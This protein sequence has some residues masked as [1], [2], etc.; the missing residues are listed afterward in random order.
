MLAVFQQNFR[1]FQLYG[2]VCVVVL[3]GPVQVVHVGR[4]KP[5]FFRD[6][7]IAL[8]LGIGNLHIVGEQKLCKQPGGQHLLGVVLLE[9]AHA[10]PLGDHFGVFG[11]VLGHRVNR[12]LK[13]DN[14]VLA[15]VKQW[16]VAAHPGCT[17][18][19][20]NGENALAGV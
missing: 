10:W 9:Q 18:S 6:G 20:V 15:D 3:T 1:G 12:R 8:R 19:G 2:I 11:V 14:G 7:H 4:V 17:R 16:G 5:G 13:A